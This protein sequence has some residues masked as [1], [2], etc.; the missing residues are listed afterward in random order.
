[1]LRNVLKSLMHIILAVT[2]NISTDQRVIR[3]AHTL[4]NMQARIT[5]I[6]R[7][8]HGK[9]SLSDPRFDAIR[10]NL[11]F[12]KGALFYAEYNIRLFFRLLLMKADVLVS[13]DLDTLPAVY[14]ASKIKNA[15]LV[16]DSHEYFTEVP[17]LKNRRF[18]RR[19]W[20]K[21]ESRMLPHI[22]YSSTVSP[23]IADAYRKKYGIHMEVIRNLPFRRLAK[24][25][26]EFHLR[27]QSEKILLYQGALNMGRGLE[28]AIKAMKYTENTVLVIIGHG[29]VEK[30]LRELTR[31]LGLAERVT[32]TGRISPDKLFDY[33]VQA[34]LGISLEED[35]GLNYRFALPNKVFD[36]IQAGVP[37]LVSDLPEVKSLVLQYDVGTINN[38]KT[39]AELGALFNQILGDE[40]KIQAWKL[41]L[42]KAAAE[43][44]WENEEQKLV[45]LYQT[46]ISGRVS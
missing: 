23:P 16:Y 42:K 22:H 28:M 5:I 40:T 31:S 44:C 30:E 11:I 33:T 32:F 38:S 12:N 9:Q 20:E 2:N 19:I 24:A 27:K 18:V 45:N 6:G 10:M 37:V 43:L 46:A 35:L 17:E 26:P 3:T 13:N 21:I 15:V 41:N 7:R 39:P 8:F 36:Y 29:D 34:D 1:V 4:H 25:G 14:L